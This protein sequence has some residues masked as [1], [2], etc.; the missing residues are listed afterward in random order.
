[1]TKPTETEIQLD[2]DEEISCYYAIW[3]PMPA[4][5]LGNTRKAALEDLRAAARFGIDFKIDQQRQLFEESRR[6]P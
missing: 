1:M 5:G 3:Q 2:F 4:V 6:R